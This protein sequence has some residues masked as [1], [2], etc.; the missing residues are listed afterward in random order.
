[1]A[2][3][4]LIV[5]AS[6][7]PH[8]NSA[9][10]A[11]LCSEVFDREGR[12]WEQVDLRGL[13]IAPCRDCGLCRQGKA[14]YCAQRDDMAELYDK[15][16]QCEALLFVSPIY[17]FTFTAQLK[18][19]ID[20]LYGLWNWNPDFLAGK[21]TGAVLVYADEDVYS[22]GAINAITTFE[23]M[24]RFAKADCRGF[25]Y[26]TAGAPGDAAGN[27]DLRERTRKLALALA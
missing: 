25:A 19:F 4:I 14:K 22:S 5:N 6:P 2:A 26:G 8:G 7:R 16:L 21:R 1:M 20:R 23:H 17:F 24:F 10:L 11:S 15:V 18:G 13:K 9:H 3:Q 12:S 27:E